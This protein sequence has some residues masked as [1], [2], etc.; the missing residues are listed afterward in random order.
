VLKPLKHNVHRAATAYL[1]R[2]EVA[3]VEKEEAEKAQPSRRHR[4]ATA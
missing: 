2:I 4:R 3:T 1:V